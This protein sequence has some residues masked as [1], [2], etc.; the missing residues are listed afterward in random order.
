MKKLVI[1]AVLGMAFSCSQK[2]ET[3]EEKTFPVTTLQV[4]DTVLFREYITDIQAVQKVDEGQR[5]KKG[6]PLFKINDA[7]YQS[8]Y[9]EAQANLSSA[10]ADASAAQLEL[11]RVSTLVDKNI[12]STTELKLAQSKLDAANAQVESA[13]SIKSSVAIKL[14]HATITAPFDGVIGLLPYKIGSLIEE[15]ALF[16]TLLDNQTIFAYFEVSENDYLTYEERLADLKKNAFQVSLKLANNEL[17][18]HVGNVETTENEFNSSTGTIAFRARFSNPT[19]LLKHGSTGKVI[20][21]MDQ[22]DVVLVPQK[23]TFEIQDKT[24]V[25]VINDSNKVEIKS[26]IPK[27]RMSHFYIVQEG[28]E[29]GERIIY[30]GIQDAREGMQIQPE[31]FSMD[32]LLVSN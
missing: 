18:E 17:Y 28:L 10:I 12:M 14:S 19:G 4:Q 29:G 31:H 5:V 21:T 16:T 22:D 7:E 2:Q 3:I 9:A 23:S 27:A 8:A 24:Y 30:E 11:D 6:Q 13:R 20:L 1:L 25:Y 15:G 32:K 26:F